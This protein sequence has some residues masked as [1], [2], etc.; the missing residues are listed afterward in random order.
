MSNIRW[1]VDPKSSKPL[2]FDDPEFV[3][4]LE[5]DHGNADDG[6]KAGPLA[7]LLGVKRATD[8]D[9]GG[10]IEDGV[11]IHARHGI[12]GV[13]EDR[14]LT[15]AQMSGERVNIEIANNRWFA[16]WVHRVTDECD[17]SGVPTDLQSSNR[18]K[19]E[20]AFGQLPTG[21]RKALITRLRVHADAASE[22]AMRDPL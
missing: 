5:A 21:V 1:S 7:M 13:D 16:T 6:K 11:A 22:P 14:L 3:E 8:Y 9:F 15:N 18:K 12:T 17:P 2:R 20:E 4:A 10:F 19:R